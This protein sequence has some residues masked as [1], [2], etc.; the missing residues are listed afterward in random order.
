[1]KLAELNNA[2]DLKGVDL[3]AAAKWLLFDSGTSP[4]EINKHT[5]VS[6]P[7]LYNYKKHRTDIYSAQYRV[8]QAMAKYALEKGFT[9]V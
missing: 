4:Y 1:M 5:T 9:N 2:T 3:M 7:T 8:V 6:L